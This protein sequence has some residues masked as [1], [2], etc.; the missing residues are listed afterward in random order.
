MNRTL[1]FAGL[2]FGLVVSA[3]TCEPAKPPLPEAR[4]DSVFVF[5]DDAFA[6]PNFGGRG[7]GA[8]LNPDLLE[9]LHGKA[10]VCEPASTECRLTPLAKE[11][12]RSVNEAMEGGRCEGFA[13]LSG[14][15]ATGEIDVEGFGAE[16][17]RELELDGNRALGGEIAYWFST[18]FLGDIVQGSTQV[19]SGEDAVRF[20]TDAFAA[21]G[22]A[23]FRIGIARVD[24]AGY[25]TGGHAVLATGVGPGEDDGTY[26]IFVYD[27]NLPDA[28]RAIV[29]DVEAGTWEYLASTNPDD[30]AALYQGTPDNGNVLFVAALPPRQ[31]QH[32]C[33]F[34]DDEASLQQVFGSAGAV[35][36]VEDASGARTG[37]VDGKIVNEI[38][39]SATVP[40]LSANNIDRA[41]TLTVLPQ[42]SVTLTVTQGQSGEPADVRLFAPDLMVA[43]TDLQFGEGGDGDAVLQ[44]NEDGTEVTFV[45][46]DGGE[47]ASLTVGTTSEDGT[48]TITSVTLPEGES[49]GAVAITTDEQGNP[50]IDVE[51][52][53]DTAIEVEVS[54]SGP[55][56]Q[57]SYSGTVEIPEGGSAT[58]LVDDWA[59]NGG[60]LGAAIDEDGDGEPDQTVVVEETEPLVPPAAPTGLVATADGAGKIALGW[61]DAA[62]DELAY[63]V[64]RDGGNGFAAVA[65]LPVDA[66]AYVDRA[67]LPSTSYRY[68]VRA[69][70]DG[71]ASDY[72]NV[73]T[74]TT[75]ARSTFAIGGTVTGLRGS[76]VLVNRGTNEE[77]TVD[78]D[79]AFTFVTT[80]DAGTTFDVAVSTQPRGQRCDVAAGLGVVTA[81]VTAVRVTCV[82]VFFVGG[83]VE[84][85]TSGGLIL[86]NDGGDPLPV[87]DN[88][89]FTFATAVALG[90]PY[91]VAVRRQPPGHECVVEAGDGVVDGPVQGV[92]VLCALLEEPTFTVSV[93]VTGLGDPPATGLVL[94]NNGGDDLAVLQDGDAAFAT[95]L[96]LGAPYDV[97]VLRQPA[98]SVCVV[99]GGSGVADADVVVDVICGPEC[100]P[101]QADPDGDP[102]TAC[103]ACAEGEFCAGGAAD[104]VACATGEVDDDNSPATACVACVAGQFCAGGAADAVSCVGTQ[105]D[106]DNN[107]ATP[108]V[109]T[110][111]VGGTVSAPSFAQVVITNR[112]GSDVVNVVANATTFAAS[113]RF[114]AGESYDFVAVGE[115]VTCAVT[116]GTGTVS[117]DVTNIAVVCTLTPLGLAL[118]NGVFPDL[119]PAAVDLAGVE[120]DVRLSAPFAAVYGTPAGVEVRNAS[121]GALAARGT[122][123][124][125]NGSTQDARIKFAAVTPSIG[126][127]PPRAGLVRGNPIG[128]TGFA[129]ACPAG[130]APIGFDADVESIVEGLS[131]VC[132]ALLLDPVAL[133]ISVGTGTTLPLRGSPADA[134]R[135]VARCP[136]NT[137]LVAFSGR[138]GT[139]IDRVDM[140][141]APLEVTGTA[142]DLEIV[143]GASVSGGGFGG[144]G[145]GLFDRTSCLAGEIPSGMTVRAGNNIDGLGLL[146]SA[147]GFPVSLAAGDHQIA[148][149][150]TFSRTLGQLVQEGVVGSFPGFS[151]GQ[152]FTV[153]TT[154][155]LTRID[156]WL[157]PRFAG[158]DRLPSDTTIELFEVAGG[159]PTGLPLASSNTVPIEGGMNTFTFALTP[160]LDGGEVYAFVVTT[161]GPN[162]VNVG[163]ASDVYVDG[164]ALFSSEVQP[165]IDVTFQAYYG[166]EGEPSE[167]IFA[168]AA[169][170]LRVQ[171]RGLTAV[172]PST[173]FRGD[174]TPL[175]GQGVAVFGDAIVALLRDVPIPEA[176]FRGVLA[177]QACTS[178]R[179]AGCILQQAPF[180]M[181]SAV[182]GVYE[183]CVVPDVDPNNL[184]SLP[185]ACPAL[186][187]TLTIVPGAGDPD[188][189]FQSTDLV[190]QPGANESP[191][192]VGFDADGNLY[193]AGVSAGEAM[194]AR[195]FPD[196]TPDTSY[197]TAGFALAGLTTAAAAPGC[198]DVAADGTATIATAL[199][200][201]DGNN[202][203]AE[204]HVVR[205]TP[206]GG[207]DPTYGSAAGTFID[208]GNPSAEQYV[209]Q[210]CKAMSDGRLVIGA[211]FFSTGATTTFQS[212]WR[213]ADNGTFSDSNVLND[214]SFTV[215]DGL[216]M[217]SGPGDTALVV[218]RLDTTA[219]FLRVEN[220]AG[221]F[222]GSWT[223]IA[224]DPAASVAAL[225]DAVVS[226]D[227]SFVAV[228]AAVVG[229]VEVPRAIRVDLAGNLA[230]NVAFNAGNGAQGPYKI[231]PEATG[232]FLVTSGALGGPTLVRLAADLQNDPAWGLGGV[233]TIPELNDAVDVAVDAAGRVVVGGRVD[234]DSN[235]DGIVDGS[236]MRAVRF[237]SGP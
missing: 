74:A 132:G 111:T 77:L 21:G 47:G 117:A 166:G 236:A 136:A 88:G 61:Q 71:V 131:V 53:G 110:F 25:L 92:V 157:A 195:L 49:V 228:G 23:P 17:G 160:T 121:S 63:E 79:G 226:G 214:P 141:C 82:D 27:N 113:R 183:V 218:G 206:A 57:G 154:A 68:R 162:Q 105:I 144:D 103:V 94:Q 73:A 99:A 213:L 86:E 120:F 65:V 15:M 147:V 137:I 20:L 142:P 109:D 51:A 83:T 168:T 13:I 5:D 48:Q 194:V 177:P 8:A 139:L 186:S 96:L 91:A 39:G 150:S 4:V 44:T 149:S 193:V 148:L 11:Y 93:A 125:R 107:P 55:G 72:S 126:L 135:T 31:G 119:L 167:R 235:F 237:V 114:L 81:A 159:V 170:P 34:C 129:D 46:A 152:T 211:S 220:T 64:E 90:A 98:G 22:A 224:L 173:I 179:Q 210:G 201:T 85:L 40:L 116:N 212:L 231:A 178:R 161:E 7:R 197:G 192:V 30:A 188:A 230:A 229:D 217:V 209:V 18:Q 143:V 172:T 104:P 165:D 33:A 29:V 227:G 130:E 106:A 158:E 108:C 187:P 118:E 219:G 191:S 3:C 14:L 37:E 216:T 215:E 234:L 151:I 225:S 221:M 203:P 36:A 198:L 54:S 69:L 16:R 102:A 19:L 60:E 97:T 43:V 222:F 123:A 87:D 169:Q 10:D 78:A 200:G 24:A 124:L 67:L 176:L 140:D 58:L 28:E 80:Q 75:A 189:S 12:M 133:T 153:P 180:S 122:W 41:G 185:D 156:V 6:F 181:G 204:L 1:R 146:C 163:F 134:V 89:P 171:P 32:P 84:G 199:T 155:V 100:L 233:V 164:T 127:G 207:I 128:A 182:P 112:T 202:N 138:A 62:T 50:T 115:A 174:P 26:S 95:P 38:D 184:S 232:R 101:G 76:V 42:Q 45:P 70:G 190:R 35:V 196:G 52:E 9:R 56:G 205:F 66:T 59:E 223:S 175:L 208:D 145:G 2:A